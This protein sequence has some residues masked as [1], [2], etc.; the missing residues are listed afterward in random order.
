M[1]EKM[2]AKDPDFYRKIALKAQESWRSNGRAPRGFA[3]MDPEELRAASAKGGRI[4][5]R[6]PK[7]EVKR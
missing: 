7:K 3:A 1:A 5:K 2:K 6:G 4:S